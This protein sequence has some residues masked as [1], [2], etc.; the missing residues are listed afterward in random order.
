MVAHRLHGVDHRQAVQALA[1][2]QP[3]DQGGGQSPAAHLHEH[4]VESGRSGSVGSQG[5]SV[6][7]QSGR[8]RIGSVGSQSGRARV[9]G[10]GGVGS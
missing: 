4:P 2:G 10:V 8:A 6:G 5:G 1:G 7:S 3:G 9:R